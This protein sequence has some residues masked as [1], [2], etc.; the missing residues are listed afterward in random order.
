[1]AKEKEWDLIGTA[2][3]EDGSV[4]LK[5][6]LKAYR[7]TLSSTYRCQVCPV[8]LTNHEMRY[9]VTECVCE[10]C[11]SGV[12]KCPYVM[13]ILQCV[14]EKSM[15][16]FAIGCHLSAL[17]PV[18]TA[19]T[20][21]MKV[22]TKELVQQGYKPAK[23]RKE[24]LKMYDKSLTYKVPPLKTIQNHVAYLKRSKMENSDKISDMIALV[25]K[26]LIDECTGD[27]E[28]FCFG[29][30]YHSNGTPH[31]GDGS[32]GDPFVIGITT[33]KLLRQADQDPERCIYHFDSTYKTNS[34]DYNLYILGVSDASRQ[35][36]PTAFFISSQG[37]EIQCYYMLSSLQKVYRAI[38]QKDMEIK[39]FLGDADP[40]QRNAFRGCF[41]GRECTSQY[42]MCFFHVA[43][44]VRKYVQKI[45]KK[46]VLRWKI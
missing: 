28:P 34:V 43:Y 17:R 41:G 4:K 15:K 24:L 11:N 2:Q 38:L 9:H 46:L 16:V 8:N 21:K 39:Y 19:Y 25:K 10:K 5:E 31:V 13:R 3:N 33:R 26:H 40:A 1:M 18:R 14:H 42:I 36:H 45:K 20:E 30:E 22:A 6:S 37:T 12:E 29:P 7:V 35:F 23:I 27:E 32:D 44:N